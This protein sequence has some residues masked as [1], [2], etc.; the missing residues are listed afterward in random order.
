VSLDPQNQFVS[1]TAAGTDAS[2]AT[3]IP[4]MGLWTVVLATSLTGGAD[5][6]LLPS[7]AE[8]A[9][10]G[11]IVEVHQAPGTSGYPHIYTVSGGYTGPVTG[12]GVGGINVLL[13]MIASDIW[14]ILLIT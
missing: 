3:P 5:G 9:L 1:L 6:L 2:T 13:R 8:G 11:D 4:R 14:A 7:V 10:L 12:G